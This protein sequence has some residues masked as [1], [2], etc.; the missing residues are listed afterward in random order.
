M[1]KKIRKI[2][3]KKEFLKQVKIIEASADFDAQW[4]LSQ[5][6]DVAQKKSNPAKHYLKF[7]W[8]EGRKPSATFDT[9]QYIKENPTS[10]WRCRINSSSIII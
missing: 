3:E 10:P 8:K 4:Y 2:K 6:P 5:Y 9:K 7:G 1:L